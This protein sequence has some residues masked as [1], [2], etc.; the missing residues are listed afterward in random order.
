MT[1]ALDRQDD[2]R[3]DQPDGHG[4]EQVRH[5][6]AV[7][8]GQP[9]DRQRGGLDAPE[10]PDA[11][12]HR[13]ANGGRDEARQERRDQRR[14]EPDAGLHQKH[15]RRHR[16]AEQR[17]DG[18][19]GPRG[20]QHGALARAEARQSRRGHAH[21]R[22]QRDQR[23]LGA[24]HRT[25]GQAGE[26][27][28]GHARPVREPGSAP[29]SG[30]G[31]ARGRRRPGAAPAPPPPARRPPPAA[32]PP[33]T[34]EARSTRARSGGR[35]TAG[36]G[37]GS[38]GRGSRRRAARPERRSAPPAPRVSGRRLHSAARPGPG[39]ARS[40]SS[41]GRHPGLVEVSMASTL[42]APRSP[43]FCL[44]VGPPMI[45]RA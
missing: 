28:Q 22:P 10:V 37:P 19:E 30:P 21:H 7:V 3:R 16:T 24:D 34:R 17:G 44:M 39:P 11:H 13:V 9:G 32:P 20:G 31:A 8:V 14:S 33:G 40:A 23:R 38:R 27:G 4:R 6:G 12:E 42:R 2:Q 35:S 41:S 43:G 25:E 1:E 36:S 26:S 15:A 5:A 45:E 18:G 29:S